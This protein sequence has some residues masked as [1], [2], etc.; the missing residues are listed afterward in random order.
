MRQPM[1]IRRVASRVS[2]AAAFCN[3]PKTLGFLETE[4]FGLATILDIAPMTC[5]FVHLCQRYNLQ[6]FDP[7][8][9]HDT[10]SDTPPIMHN[11]DTIIRV[12]SIP[13]GSP[14]V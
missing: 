4:Y 3:M 9:H 12:V 1:A 5:T 11:A 7:I 6:L 8:I 10:T 14:E 13:H 2:I